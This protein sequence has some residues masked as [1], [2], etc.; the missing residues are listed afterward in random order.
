MP[1]C[2][3][4]TRAKSRV[5]FWD[6]SKFAVTY[7]FESAP[8]RE[9]RDKRNNIKKGNSFHCPLSFSFFSHF[10]FL[11]FPFLFHALTNSFL[12]LF[13]SF[14]IFAIEED[15]FFSLSFSLSLPFSFFFFNLVFLSFFLSPGVFGRLTFHP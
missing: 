15:N 9:E 11:L 13:S 12:F 5:P 8:L 2:P 14:L 1:V 10:T 6:S 7:A 3:V 4:F